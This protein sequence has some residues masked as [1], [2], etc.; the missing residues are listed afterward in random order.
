MKTKPFPYAK[1]EHHKAWAVVD[2]A[3]RVLVK[4][5]DLV[6]QTEHRYVVGYVIKE[7]LDSN[8]LRLPAKRRQGTARQHRRTI[9]SR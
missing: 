2:N 8:M 9:S 1:H 5:R 4:N 7:L 6:E 3:V